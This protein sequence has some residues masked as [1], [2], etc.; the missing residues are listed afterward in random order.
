MHFF[1]FLLEWASIVW[2]LCCSF[3]SPT[4]PFFFYAR[5]I[6]CT[7]SVVCLNSTLGHC[8]LIREVYHYNLERNRVELER[9]SPSGAAL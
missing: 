3:L 9:L 1:F 7:L 2:H 4:P 8:S 5:L 6:I